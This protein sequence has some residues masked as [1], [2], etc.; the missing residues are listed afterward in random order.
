MCHFRGSAVVVQLYV[1][2]VNRI[3]LAEKPHFD[4]YM[5]FLLNF[6][7]EAGSQMLL[8]LDLIPFMPTFICK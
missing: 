3:K 5:S 6:E 4:S 1:E 7:K 2:W 8:S